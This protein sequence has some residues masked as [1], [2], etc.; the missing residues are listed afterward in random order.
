M[1]EEALRHAAEQDALCP[2]LAVRTDDEQVRLPIRS[3]RLPN[4]PRTVGTVRNRRMWLAAG[5]DEGFA[6][7]V[8]SCV[9]NY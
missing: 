1:I 3:R 4:R 7:V 6:V 8:N 9:V 2:S 5:L